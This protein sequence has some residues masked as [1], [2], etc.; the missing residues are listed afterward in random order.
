MAFRKNEID[1][2]GK[3]LMSKN[4]KNLKDLKINK[5]Q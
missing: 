5:Y 3:F 4:W 1:S 2:N